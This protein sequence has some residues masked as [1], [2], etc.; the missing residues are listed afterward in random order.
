MNRVY[1]NVKRAADPRRCRPKL[2]RASTRSHVNWVWGLDAPADI[3]GSDLP[4]V[5]MVGVNEE[6]GRT[7]VPYLLPSHSPKLRMLMATVTERQREAYLA[8][9][10]CG[11]TT[12]AIG[13]SEP[14]AGFDP[15]T[16]TMRAVWDGVDWVINGRKTC[17]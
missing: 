7:V 12:S 2:M 5:A 16:M 3:G 13:I 10:A 17:T 4:A 6:M 9:Y 1:S 14:G 8:P 11:D 15:S